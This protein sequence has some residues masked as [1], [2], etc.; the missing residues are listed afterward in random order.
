MGD[1][2]RHVGTT[3]TLAR[4]GK[5]LKTT[6]IAYEP[7]VRTTSSLARAP[8]EQAFLY[9]LQTTIATLQ[10]VRLLRDLESYLKHKDSSK[11]TEAER[12]HIQDFNAPNY[13][14]TSFIPAL[15]TMDLA[16]EAGEASAEFSQET[17]DFLNT[18][19]N[20]IK[21]MPLRTIIEENDNNIRAGK[22]SIELASFNELRELVK[23]SE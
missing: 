8:S 20:K 14:E 23:P 19:L 1:L 6:S 2:S 21:A 5:S 7:I 4:T 10:L 13:F 22:L 15:A 17:V 16:N 9:S 12:Q 11:L 18:S 3:L